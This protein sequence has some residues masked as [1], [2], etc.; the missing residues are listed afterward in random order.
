MPAKRV[1]HSRVGQLALPTGEVVFV[2]SHCVRVWRY[3]TKPKSTFSQ[4][5]QTLSEAA[6]K[7]GKWTSQPRWYPR[8][9][10]GNVLW[11]QVNADTVLIV[12]RVGTSLTATMCIYPGGEPKPAQI[13]RRQR[14]RPFRGVQGRRGNRRRLPAAGANPRP[15]VANSRQRRYNVLL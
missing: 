4:A 6:G 10:P 2:T 9:N 1:N 15:P 7:F 5:L 11:L 13:G 3:H 12:Q 14:G 8:N